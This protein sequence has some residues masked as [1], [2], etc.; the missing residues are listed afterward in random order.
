MTHLDWKQDHQECRYDEQ[1]RRHEYGS[2][3]SA[4]REFKKVASVTTCMSLHAPVRA[5]RS[6]CARRTS[7]SDFDDGSE[8]SSDSVETARESIASSS[9]G[10]REHLAMG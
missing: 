5:A 1:G 8:D 3:I 2:K 9:M 4:K 6:S 7:C 10:C